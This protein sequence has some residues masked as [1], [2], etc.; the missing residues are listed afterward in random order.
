MRA[1]KIFYLSFLIIIFFIGKKPFSRELKN[2]TGAEILAL[3]G[4]LKDLELDQTKIAAVENLSLKR[5]AGLFHL[6]KGEIYL[7][8]PVSGKITGAIFIGEGTFD[9]TPPAEI[10]RY[11]LVKFTDHKDLSVDFKELYLR[12]SDSTLKEFGDLSYRT[13]NIPGEAKDILNSSTKRSGKILNLNLRILEDVL[14]GT[15]GGLLYAEIKPE[16][17][18][19]I[20]FIYDPKGLEEIRLMQEYR[21]GIDLVCSFNKGIGPEQGFPIPAENKDEIKIKHYKIEVTLPTSG[22]LISNCEVDLSFLKSGLKIIDFDLSERLKVSQVKDESGKELS[23]IQEKDSPEV[24]VILE[25]PS[26]SSQNQKL[27]FTY[28]GDILDRN[29]YGDFYIESSDFWYP[30]YGYN[31][32]STFDLTFRTSPDFKFVSIG[33]KVIEKKEKDFLFTQWIEETPVALAS[34]NLGNFEVLDLKNDGIPDVSVYYVEESHRQFTSDYNRLSAIFPELDIVLR[35]AHMMENTGADVVNSLNFFQSVFGK[36]PFS[37]ISVTEIPASYGQG[38]PGLL[39]L[40]WI[41]F[42]NEVKGSTEFFRAH[43]VSHQWWGHLVGW[44]TYHDMWLCEGLAEYSGAWFTQ[45]SLKNNKSFFEIIENWRKNISGKGE[46]ESKGTKAGPLWL[47]SSL[48]SSKSLDYQ[49]LVYQKG[50]YIFHMLRNMMMDFKTMSDDKFIAMMKD[51]IQTYSGKEPSTEDFKRVVDKHFGENMDWFFREWVYGVEIPTYTVSSDIE[52]TEDGKYM[53]NLKV[54]QENVSDGFKMVVPVVMNF[55]GDKYAI[56][57]VLIDKPYTELKLPKVSIEPKGI[58]FNPFN[59]V[60][61]EV[62]YK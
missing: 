61:C 50:A 21:D 42:Q 52:Q 27:T 35:D 22:N 2:L 53:I 9:F 48:S 45:V 15:N 7:L 13:G 55:G 25:N 32:R 28:S 43:E 17:G 33:K 56:V 47:G 4:Q 8:Q 1:I 10:E 11:Q 23:F 58:V 36:C 14:T 26:D 29:V 19:R 6:K 60:L 41:S 24:A 3:Y 31:N 54:K 62:K 20:F 38:F 34:F 46:L 51:F 30:Q 57:K 12:F 44:K 49:T 39:H 18:K 16:S 5:D 37:K 40:S 59:S